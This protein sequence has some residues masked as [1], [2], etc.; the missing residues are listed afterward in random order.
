MMRYPQIA[1]HLFNTPLMLHPAKLDAIIHGLGPRFGIETAAPEA[2]LV[3]TS[4]REPGG[5][6]IMNGVAVIDV[7]GVLAHRTRMEGDSSWVQGYDGLARQFDQALADPLAQAILLHIDSPGGEVAGAFQLADQIRAA[8]GTKPIHAIAGDLAASAAYLIASAADTI[9]VTR[10]GEV[11]SIGV[12]LRHV[13]IS[14]ALAQEGVRVTSI[15]AGAHKIDGNPYQQLPPDVH[16]DL[17]AQVNHYY[18]LFVDAVAVGRGMTPD[19]IRATEARVFTADQAVQMALADMIATPDQRIAQI[20]QQV[21]PPI[22]PRA[23]AQPPRGHAMADTQGAAVPTMTATFTQSDLD[24]AREAG[25]Q[26]GIAEGRASERRRLTA[27]L[28]L[29]QAAGREALAHKL[30]MTTDL[31]ADA[32]APILDAAPSVAKLETVSDF[33]A[34]MAR[35]G[36]P[37]IGPDQSAVDPQAEASQLW[38]RA[39]NKV[40]GRA[41]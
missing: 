30:A 28:A 12:V 38:G 26:D 5:Y 24:A 14:A 10:T 25:R 11:G 31:A 35:I 7:F 3:P 32:I 1:S 41:N 23:A 34:H 27:I 39:F 36:N 6:R 37:P 15:A 16:T 40:A 22:F 9:A 33:S 17:Q 13:D 8:R 2:Y 20:S 4:K 29:P 18:G 21:H 19:A